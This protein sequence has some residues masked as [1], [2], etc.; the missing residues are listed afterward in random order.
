MSK[1]IFFIVLMLTVLSLPSLV[2]AQAQ[3]KIAVPNFTLESTTGEEVSLSD[4]A[5]Q[6]VVLNFWASWCPPC[7]SEMPEFQRLHNH[8]VESND[9]V[10]LMLNQTDGQ[11]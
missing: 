6:V 11:R 3:S 4:Y 10:L 2:L 5:G 1:R 7:R 8:L 9:A